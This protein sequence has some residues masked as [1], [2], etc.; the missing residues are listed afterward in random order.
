MVM[1]VTLSMVSVMF[2]EQTLVIQKANGLSNSGVL[3]ISQLDCSF[4][5]CRL[6]EFVGWPLLCL[7]TCGHVGMVICYLASFLF[8]M[9][10]FVVM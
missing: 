1:Y 5:L 6:L 10:Y 4:L 2:L 9:L 3:L 8:L 7:F